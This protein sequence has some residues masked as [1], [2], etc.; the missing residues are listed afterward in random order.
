MKESSKIILKRKDTVG[1]PKYARKILIHFHDENS[2]IVDYSIIEKGK[3]NTSMG[4]YDRIL[5]V[6]EETAKIEKYPKRLEL[7]IK[8]K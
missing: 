3:S 5:Q 8:T 4:F 7:T 2:K 6:M 1:K